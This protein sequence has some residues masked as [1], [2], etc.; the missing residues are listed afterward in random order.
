MK[1]HVQRHVRNRTCASCDRCDP[2]ASNT[3]EVSSVSSIQTILRTRHAV[4]GTCCTQLPHYACLMF[5]HGSHEMPPAWMRI[6]FMCVA[7]LPGL[8]SLRLLHQPPNSQQLRCCG[9]TPHK[10]QPPT[11]PSQQPAGDA[12]IFCDAT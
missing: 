6:Q 12:Y 2:R 1:T 9:L 3:R 7:C 5:M 11:P 4:H 10:P 8:A